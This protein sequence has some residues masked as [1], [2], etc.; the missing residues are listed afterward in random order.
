MN[1]IIPPLEEKWTLTFTI[2][3]LEGFGYLIEEKMN[4]MAGRRTTPYSLQEMLELKGLDRLLRYLSER[5]ISLYR[6]PLKG[7]GKHHCTVSL[8][9]VD[10]HLLHSRLLYDYDNMEVREL[11]GRIDK[12][13]VKYNRRLELTRQKDQEEIRKLNLS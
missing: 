9:V 2:N 3:Q 1:Y 4:R 8:N 5:C 12:I 13:L 7:I 11:M 10:L 6:A